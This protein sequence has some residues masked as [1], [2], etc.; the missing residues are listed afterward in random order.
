VVEHY[1][2]C[3]PGISAGTGTV[4][5]KYDEHKPR[6]PKERLL[7]RGFA[8]LIVWQG[9]LLAGVTLAAFAVGMAWYGVEGTGLRHAVTISFMTLAL[10]QTFHAFN[11]RSQ[12]D[13]AFNKRLFTNKWLWGAVALCVMLQLAA[14]Y[15]PFLQTILRTVPLSLSDWG[16]VLSFSLLPIVVVEF[17]KVVH[18]LILSQQ[19]RQ[20][21]R[22]L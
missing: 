11:A 19:K 18:R 13:S 7:N 3:L 6:D 15:V 20:R 8:G 10:A 14:V 16:L 9:L 21:V 5:A 4:R 2:G 12:M 1:Y 22:K 17:V